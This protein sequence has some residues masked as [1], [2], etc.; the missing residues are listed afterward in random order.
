LTDHF[1][2][3]AFRGFNGLESEGAQDDGRDEE[4]DE[5]EDTDDQVIRKEVISPEYSRLR[6][7]KG[8]RAYWFT[9]AADV[10]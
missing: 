5:D 10:L 6:A 4:Q 2:F 1:R 9:T 7:W 8:L 3:Q